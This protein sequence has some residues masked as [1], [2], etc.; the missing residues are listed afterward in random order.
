MAMHNLTQ[1]SPPYVRFT[2]DNYGHKS[3]NIISF[4]MDNHTMLYTILL[5][6]M[7]RVRVAVMDLTVCT[8]YELQW[9]QESAVVG[10]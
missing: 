5:L 6:P 2:V 8:H 10:R 7:V 1:Y 4:T 3:N 9:C